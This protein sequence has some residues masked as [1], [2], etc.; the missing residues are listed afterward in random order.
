MSPRRREPPAAESTTLVTGSTGRDAVDS[1]RTAESTRTRT[2]TSVTAGR[3]AAHRDVVV[4][5]VVWVNEH[6]CHGER[7][8]RARAGT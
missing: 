4:G 2:E 1:E 7:A 5:R 6:S 3:V 8:Y